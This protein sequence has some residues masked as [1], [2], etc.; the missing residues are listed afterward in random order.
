[1]SP[2]TL[3]LEQGETGVIEATVIPASSPVTWATS[4]SAI[5]TVDNGTVTAVGE[6]SA[7][8]TASITVE[9]VEYTDTA[10]V[11]VAAAPAQWEMVRDFTN[12][13]VWTDG[14]LWSKQDYYDYSR[15]TYIEHNGEGNDITF[16]YNPNGNSS[17]VY[18]DARATPAGFVFDDSYDYALRIEYN[19]DSTIE[20]QL[21]LV[22]LS[23]SI[24]KADGW[25]GTGLQQYNH[26]E[27]ILPLTVS[28]AQ[29]DRLLSI[30]ARASG[31]Y[32]TYMEAR[33]K[34]ELVRKAKE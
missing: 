13:S 11:D 17:T 24:F 26:V 1:M 20:T 21:S 27:T 2:K 15:M 12:E 22:G 30:Q 34:F 7:L 16:C 3:Q 28:N 8:I 32:P 6:G 5:A 25:G 29:G 19:T 31:S 18:L 33:F 10:T 23:D 14:T 4:D 9:G